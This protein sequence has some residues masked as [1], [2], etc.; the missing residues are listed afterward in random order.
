MFG[1][2]GDIVDS[3]TLSVS[4]SVDGR[5]RVAFL[6]APVGTLTLTVI[7]S[8]DGKVVTRSAQV[9]TTAGGVTAV[10]P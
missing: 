4:V 2:S 10:Q 6:D 3:S 9:V 5:S 1:A 7:Y 8:R